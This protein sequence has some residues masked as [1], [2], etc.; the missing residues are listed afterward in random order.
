MIQALTYM[1]VVSVVCIVW[2]FPLYLHAA[3]RKKISV[4]VEAII[5]SFFVGLAFISILSSWISLFL[6]VKFQ[7]LV[8]FT[9]PLLFLQFSI[10]KKIH[11]KVDFTILKS[12]KKIEIIFVFICLLLFCF[13]ATGKPTMEDSD[14][15]HIQNI[16]W[17]H[18]YGTIPGLANLYLRYGFYSNWFHAI[19]I[20]KLPFV[21]NN[22]L[23]LN[24]AITTWTF[25]FLFY[26]YKAYADQKTLSS[27]H[28]SF[29]YFST[30]IFMLF[31]WDLFRV[32]S[33][34]TSYDFV[35]TA[36]VLISIH[37]LL[38]RL[39]FNNQSLE[40]KYVLIVLVIASPFFKITGLFT[41]FLLLVYIF[42]SEKKLK[43]LMEAMA[44]GFVCLIPYLYKNF[45]QTGYPFF[46]Y[47][48]IDFFH[49][50][51]KVPNVLVNRFNEY[52]F[53]GNHY[54]NQDIPKI[55]WGNSS[56]FSYYSNWFL[57]LVKA[58]QL[59]ILAALISFPISI[60]LLKKL[61]RQKMSQIFIMQMVCLT[62]GFFWLITSPD[63]R[64]IF[65]FLIFAVFF[66]LTAMFTRF[67][68]R[69][70]YSIVMGIFIL[71]IG[72]Y[73]FNKAKNSFKINNLINVKLIDVPPYKKV[74]IN[75][76]S[77]NI[78]EK[79]NNNWNSR[80]IDCPLPCIYQANPH[81][82]LRQK[83]ISGGFQMDINLDS[84][85]INNYRY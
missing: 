78:P 64:F 50:D 34:S 47:T 66:P 13:L 60:P 57:H 37:L 77:Y 71:G 56:S 26:Q 83:D 65:G 45:L 17:I 35:I 54:I 49:T 52:V 76:Q 9:I 20:F 2:G 21:N 15:Y 33:S 48:F 55:A 8:V 23:Y 19:S 68:G 7:W 40:D 10:R 12:L 1:L 3:Y 29:F 38:K 61:Y 58:D 16:K 32:S 30:I 81:L 41:T 84:A 5:I 25:L 28:L 6:P 85:F 70:V 51:W 75:K 43:I 44:L 82:R 24:Q 22:F 42:F 11:W 80:C 36:F 39:I 46:P 72:Y 18:E 14:L 62:V 59:L 79:I 67:I 53:L 27:H 63:P 31:E 4:T 69:Q 73:V 74:I